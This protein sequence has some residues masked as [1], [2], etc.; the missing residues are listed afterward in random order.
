MI[1]CL[2]PEVRYQIEKRKT[3]QALIDA[4]IGANVHIDLWMMGH[5]VHAR[6]RKDS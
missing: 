1:S 5:V 6:T 2:S 3:R 4:H